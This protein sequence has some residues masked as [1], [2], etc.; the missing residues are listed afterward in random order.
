M[1]SILNRARNRATS[2]SVLVLVAVALAVLPACGAG[3]TGDVGDSLGVES[4]NLTGVPAAPSNLLAA[5]VSASEIDLAWNDNSTNETGF[6]VERAT[7][8]LGPFTQITVT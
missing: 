2:P 1:Q 4:S 3:N 7:N 5:G 8:H 6:K